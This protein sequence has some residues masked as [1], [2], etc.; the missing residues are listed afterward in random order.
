MA[1]K[2]QTSVVTRIH[3][4]AVQSSILPEAP[5]VRFLDAGITAAVA[6][7]SVLWTATRPT[8]GSQLGWAAFWVL[9]GGLMAVE[10]GGEL[11][12]GGFGVMASNAS[13]MAL[14]IAHPTLGS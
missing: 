5:D 7:G 12:Y 11:R 13:Y 3:P 4:A 2:K 1:Q 14:R 8:I 9:L 10:G 6:A